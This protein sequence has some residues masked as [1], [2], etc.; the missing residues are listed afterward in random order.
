LYVN[1]LQENLFIPRKVVFDYRSGG[2]AEVVVRTM[3]ES[4]FD[5]LF[6]A[7]GAGSGYDPQ[8]ALAASEVWHHAYCIFEPGFS[9]SGDTRSD[10]T[11]QGRTVAM[12]RYTGVVEFV[13]RKELRCTFRGISTAKFGKF[14]IRT[15]L[16]DG[17]VDLIPASPMELQPV[18]AK[19][20]N[21]DLNLVVSTSQAQAFVFSD[22]VRKTKMPRAELQKTFNNSEVLY[23]DGL[24]PRVASL[25]ANGGYEDNVFD[26]IKKPWYFWEREQGQRKRRS[27]CV[28]L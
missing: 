3:G 1:Q 25:V 27:N 5:G 12:T 7:R 10:T 26:D 22:G 13:G 14:R 11:R 2:D 24:D 21:E 23:A 28:F 20:L 19:N 6:F 18:D 15:G 8:S 17:A 16:G 9:G 4:D